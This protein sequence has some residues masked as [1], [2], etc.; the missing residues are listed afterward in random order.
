MGKLQGQRNKSSVG[1]LSPD[2]PPARG[3]VL[4]SGEWWVGAYRGGAWTP[5]GR[6]TNL[7]A[8]G[9][10]QQGSHS[11]VLLSGRAVRGALP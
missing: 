11:L 2:L 1:P 3:V 4:E 8:C 5:P 7:V 10:S 9:G 6:V